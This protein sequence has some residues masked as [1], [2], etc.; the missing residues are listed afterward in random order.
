MA[1]GSEFPSVY[2]RQVAPPASSSSNPYGM[3]HPAIPPPPMPAP[4]P[5]YVE[6]KTTA[7]PVSP[8]AAAAPPVVPAV[9]AAAPPPAA[10]AVPSFD[11]LEA[12]FAALRNNNN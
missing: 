12:R 10:G 6:D 11:D 1:P 3:A 7:A 2:Q 5:A 4:P 8:P 9:P